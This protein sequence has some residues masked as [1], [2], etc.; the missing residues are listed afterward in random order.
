MGPRFPLKRKMG[1]SKFVLFNFPFLV[2]REDK[3]AVRH[4]WPMIS[5]KLD[6]LREGE[7]G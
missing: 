4:N 6:S 3:N 1:W 7:K 5:K 2:G